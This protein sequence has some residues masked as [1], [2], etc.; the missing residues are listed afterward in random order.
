MN[1]TTCSRK[2]CKE[3]LLLAWA[4]DSQIKTHTFKKIQCKKQS[5]LQQ[6]NNLFTSVYLDNDKDK[7]ISFYP[8]KDE[9]WYRNFNHL[10]YYI[11]LN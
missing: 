10:N 11:Q 1:K 8:H 2:T 7:K 9:D 6:R 4:G 5:I 3:N